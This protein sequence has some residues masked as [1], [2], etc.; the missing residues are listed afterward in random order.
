ML[1]IAGGHGI[2]G[3]TIAKNNPNAEIVAV[4][5]AS[6]L[7]VAQENAEKAGIAG[8]FRKIPGS[9]FEVDFETGYD[10]VLITNF[11]HHF[12]IATNEG[13]LRKVHA[14]MA[15]GGRAV[16]VEFIPNEDR[17]S[18]STDATFS[19]MML[20]MV[21]A[22]VPPAAIKQMFWRVGRGPAG[23]RLASTEG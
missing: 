2:F 15:P 3:I 19:M 16:T 4:D 9:A 20:T 21:L 12:D 23:L 17:V 10:L 7:E 18:P 6:V 8:R 14:A 13:L 1:D 11:L 22:F 5:W